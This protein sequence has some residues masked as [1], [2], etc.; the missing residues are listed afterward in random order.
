MAALISDR[1]LSRTLCYKGKNELFRRKYN[2]IMQ[3]K[4][5][6]LHTLIESLLSLRFSGIISLWFS[7]SKFIKEFHQ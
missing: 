3:K 6:K 7:L 1:T 4:Q 2:E 5:K